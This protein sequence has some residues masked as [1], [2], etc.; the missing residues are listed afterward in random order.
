MVL[1]TKFVA[2]STR[3]RGY[4]RRVFLRYRHV[5]RDHPGGEAAHR[6]G[7]RLRHPRRSR[8]LHRRPQAGHSDTEQ[9]FHR[10]EHLL[11]IPDATRSHQ[12]LYGGR[13]DSESG[14]SQL[15]RSLWNRR[16]IAFGAEAQSLVILGFMLA[17]N[18]TSH[19]R[20]TEDPTY[21]DADAE[22][23]DDTGQSPAR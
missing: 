11:Q 7:N 15:G 1:G 12:N 18:A 21:A 14:F 10:A 22:T 23:T 9:G 5:P 19:A 17:Q 8:R 13:E 4:F 2:F 6:P 3:H 20:Y 16:M